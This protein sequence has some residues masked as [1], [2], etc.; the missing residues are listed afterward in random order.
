VV[1][2]Q[3]PVSFYLAAPHAAYYYRNWNLFYDHSRAGGTV[4][5][6][7]NQRF[8][9]TPDDLRAYTKCVATVWVVKAVSPVNRPF[10]IEAVWGKRLVSAT[11]VFRSVDNR[12]AVIRADLQA[13]SV[14]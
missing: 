12:L 13:E 9:S 11:E 14:C 4:D 8:L 5:R 10:E 3:P 6:W 7:S 2:G 1:V